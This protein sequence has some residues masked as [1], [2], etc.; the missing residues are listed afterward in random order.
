MFIDHILVYSLFIPTL[1]LY[2]NLP[3]IGGLTKKI[4][5]QLININSFT[6]IRYM[7]FLTHLFRLTGDFSGVLDF[8]LDFDFLFSGDLDLLSLEGDLESWESESSELLES[9]LVSTLELQL[10]IGS[11]ASPACKIV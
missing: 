11:V 7:S 8:D 2:E 1:G 6:S 3:K 10:I 9:L 5:L 4:P